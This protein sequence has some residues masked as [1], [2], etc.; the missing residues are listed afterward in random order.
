MEVVGIVTALGA[1]GINLLQG[2][3]GGVVDIILESGGKVELAHSGSTAREEVGSSS[4]SAGASKLRI[5]VPLPAALVFKR[6]AGHGSGL[7]F[8]KAAAF[9]GSRVESA[10]LFAFG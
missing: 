6:R 3:V 10:S 8:G 9:F 1:D 7:V 2:S 4:I 5:G